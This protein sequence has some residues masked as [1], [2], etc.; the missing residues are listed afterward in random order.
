MSPLLALGAAVFLLGTIVWH[1]AGFFATL[2][3][4]A[5]G[6]AVMLHYTLPRR[7]REGLTLDHLLAI[8]ILAIPVMVMSALAL[9]T[10]ATKPVEWQSFEWRRIEHA[11]LPG[12][13][14]RHM[15]PVRPGRPAEGE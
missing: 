3:A 1:F 9:W 15:F 5:C 13:T 12:D 2:T 10:L 7:W 14:W 4:W 6:L 11:R 8:S